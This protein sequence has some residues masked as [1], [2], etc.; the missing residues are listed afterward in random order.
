MLGEPSEAETRALPMPSDLTRPAPEIVAGRVSRLRIAAGAVAAAGL[1]AVVILTAVPPPRPVSMARELRERG[2]QEIARG[3]Q[4]AAVES[5][6]LASQAAA[7]TQTGPS[8]PDDAEVEAAERGLARLREVTPSARVPSLDGDVTL[9]LFE[10]GPGDDPSFGR[11]DYR[12]RFSGTVARFVCFEVESVH[13]P[14]PTRVESSFAAV[15]YKNG[16]AYATS[17]RMTRRTD[18]GARTSW[19]R[20]CIG[21][22]TPGRWE[23]GPYRFDI[24]FDGQKAV[25]H[26]FVITE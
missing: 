26:A 20:N 7:T 22:K 14:I 18:P 3:D 15:L 13:E 12:D 6:M 10:K 4:F 2:D 23:P 8:A 25:S 16:A 24:Y 19:F 21:G 5:Y 17:D 9:R 1:V 11:A